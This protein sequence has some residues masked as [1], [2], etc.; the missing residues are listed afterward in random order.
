MESAITQVGIEVCVLFVTSTGSVNFAVTK[1]NFL[2]NLLTRTVQ[3][4]FPAN[5]S[6]QEINCRFRV[7]Q[8]WQGSRSS[9][10][11]LKL[12]KINRWEGKWAMDLCFSVDATP[13]EIH[14]RYISC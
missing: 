9:K 12:I 11:I 1:D 5:V 3:G 14:A 8:L 13:L 4:T 7:D 10:S 2:Q 6:V